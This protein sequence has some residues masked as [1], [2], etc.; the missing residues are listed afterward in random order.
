MSPIFSNNL[1]PLVNWENIGFLADEDDDVSAEA[2]AKAKHEDEFRT[3]D[4]RFMIGVGTKPASPLPPN[5]TGE[6]L[7][8]G[9]PVGGYF[10][11][12]RQS[13]R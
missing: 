12:D 8:F 3:S 1:V 7:A 5:R 4:F 2:M 6:F 13:M 11:K 9:S 10:Q